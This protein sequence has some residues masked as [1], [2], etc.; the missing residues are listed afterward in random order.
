MR[1]YLK[2]LVA[3]GFADWEI[4]QFN[5]V[6]KLE[7]IAR[8]IRQGIATGCDPCVY[9]DEAFMRRDPFKTMEAMTDQEKK[10]LRAYAEC[11]F[12]EFIEEPD[13]P[14]VS[15]AQV[16][17]AADRSLR[18]FASKGIYPSTKVPQ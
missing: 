12:T 16:T 5:A 14:P 11:D 18:F 15:Q 4:A 17:E 7:Y 6:N 3:A 13:Y 10:E 8:G 1:D 9:H 2:L